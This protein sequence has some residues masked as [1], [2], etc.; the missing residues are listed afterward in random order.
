MFNSIKIG[1]Y[2]EGL[3]PIQ[4]INALHS[5]LKKW[6]KDFNDVATKYLSNY[7]YWFK[8]LQFFNK[9]KEIQK[10]RIFSA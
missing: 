4:H 9:D 3:Y 8:W 5:K 6:M 2:K 10:V 7:L 1:H